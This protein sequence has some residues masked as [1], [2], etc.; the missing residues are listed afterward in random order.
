[1][2][3]RTLVAVG[4]V[5][6]LLV[7]GLA[8]LVASSS[9]DGLAYVA[10]QV[11]FADTAEDSATAGSPLSDY[12]VRGVQNDALAGGLAGVA[13]ALVVLLLTVGLTLGVRRRARP[14]E[15]RQ[16]RPEPGAAERDRA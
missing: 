12:R 14:G 8:G 15:E 2:R 10:E 16:P 4:L 11:G 5:V 13:G 6:S 9:P 1:M 3:T 7:A